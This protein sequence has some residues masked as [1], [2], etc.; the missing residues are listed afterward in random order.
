MKTRLII[1]IAVILV[2]ASSVQAQKIRVDVDKTIEFA[3]FRSFSLADGQI[4]PNPKTGRSIISAIE[5]ELSL[6]GLKRDDVNPDIRIAVMAAADMD[7]QGVGP[8]W[9]NERYRSWGGYGNPGALMTVAKGMLMIDL[10]ETT[11]KLSIWRG[12][13]SDVF[14]APPSGDPEK[15]AIE[16]DKLVRKTVKKMFKNYPVKPRP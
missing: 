1:A 11:G 2:A 14:V 9:N 6:R 7:L 13:A 10:V 15:D 3:G 8:S 5:S 4:A 16:M 12:V